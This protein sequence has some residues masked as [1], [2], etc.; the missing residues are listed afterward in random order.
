VS[1]EAKLL[2]VVT[3]G[4]TVVTLAWLRRLWGGAGG[5][6]V[7]GAVARTEKERDA[8]GA[9]V[10]RAQVRLAPARVGKPVAERNFAPQGSWWVRA[11]LVAG[12][13][14]TLRAVTV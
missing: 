9:R 10:P 5:F 14:P 7:A 4:L 13:P 3:S 11:T 1:R 12:A 2:A 6:I 8:P